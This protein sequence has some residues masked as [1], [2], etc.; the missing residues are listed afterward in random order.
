[1]S[2]LWAP[3]QLFRLKVPYTYLWSPAL[4]PKPKDWG[5]EINV[6]GYVFLD[7]ATSYEPPESLSK[8]LAG[9][10]K[11]IYIGFG[12]ITID[13]PDS[14]T[15]LIFEA[16]QKSGV[17]ALVSK[18]WGG[19]GG[20][21]DIPENI[22]MLDNCPHDWLFP[23]VSAVIH[24]G[25]AGTTAMGLK[26]GIPT[27]IVHFFGDQP[28]WG[29]VV[30][31]AGAGARKTIPW[32]KLTA[33]KLADGITECMSVEARTAAAKLARSIANE[34]DGAANAVASFHASLPLSKTSKHSM[35]CEKYPERV[36][37]WTTKKSKKTHK[38]ERLSALAGTELVQ[39]QTLSQKDLRLIHHMDW[40]DF[41]GPGEPFTGGTAAI[42]YSAGSTIKGIASIP[43]RFHKML[44]QNNDNETPSDLPALP[45][46]KHKKFPSNSHTLQALALSTSRGVVRS[47]STL[48]KSPLDISLAITL[49]FHNAP[50]LYGDTT[51]PPPPALHLIHGY[52]SG[53]EAGFKELK[54]GF[55]AGTTGL[56]KLPILGAEEGKSRVI[57]GLEGFGKGI[58]GLVLKPIAGVFGVPVFSGMGLRREIRNFCAEEWDG[59]ERWVRE[60]RAL[61]G[62]RDQIEERK[63]KEEVVMG[64]VREEKVETGRMGEEERGGSDTEARE[65]SSIRGEES[66]D[67]GCPNTSDADDRMI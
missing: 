12:S 10:E 32:K 63:R 8:F 54:Y 7:L 25:G 50:R 51:V 11:P 43:H 31:N 20:T 23:H 34:G 41:Q 35:R 18:G 66:G 55:T 37:V 9:G 53:L 5:P 62:E 67:R 6:T 47:L 52:R 45:E 57:G 28:F 2:T 46:K 64:E 42:I 49:G 4:A 15:S 40:N 56:V 27:M 61:Q 33:Q 58:G 19:L 44:K 39:S 36:A 14:F 13:D 22:Y 59:G 17:R 1:M 38:H 21:H 3:G 26:C 48:C 29:C 24:H 16:V 65:K 60:A 30:V